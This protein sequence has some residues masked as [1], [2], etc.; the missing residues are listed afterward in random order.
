MVYGTP[1]DRRED[2]TKE[3]QTQVLG[4]TAWLSPSGQRPL[5]K[6]LADPTFPYTVSDSTMEAVHGPHSMLR[7]LPDDPRA[8]RLLVLHPPRG[9]DLE[10]PIEC[11]L[12]IE[13]LDNNPQYEA[14][15]YTCS[16]PQQ[17][18][19]VTAS[20][21]RTITQS[22]NLLTTPSAIDMILVHGR[23]FYVMTNLGFALKRLRRMEKSRVLWVDTVCISMQDLA[24][25]SAQLQHISDI[26]R[27]ARNVVAWLGEENETSERAM[28]LLTDS[29]ADTIKGIEKSL[30]E[31]DF[32]SC[33]SP[34]GAGILDELFSRPLWSRSWIIQEVVCAQQVTLHCGS[35]SID[36]D[37]MCNIANLPSYGRPHHLDGCQGLEASQLINE[38]YKRAPA[39]ALQ[40][41]RQGYLAGQRLELA[42]LLQLA[43]RHHCTAQHDKIYSILS[44]LPNSDAKSSLLKVDYNKTWEDAYSLAAEFIINKS[45]DLEILYWIDPMLKARGLPSWVPDWRHI[46]PPLLKVKLFNADAGY[47][48]ANL[49]SFSEATSTITLDR[50]VVDCITN[51]DE[52]E[53]SYSLDKGVQGLVLRINQDLIDQVPADQNKF[54]ACWR[55]ILGDH[56]VDEN[57]VPRRIR[58]SGIDPPQDRAQLEKIETRLRSQKYVHLRGQRFFYTEKG[59]VGSVASSA[60]VGDIVAILLGGKV[61][62]VLRRGQHN[63]YGRKL[64]QM[65]SPW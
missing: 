16:E 19:A 7:T 43:R 36:W 62:F 18:S 13:S 3:I 27:S 63:E 65:I 12:C 52:E 57:E 42:D 10:E 24:E 1:T 29:S 5:M 55:L 11:S 56:V 14:L 46:V 25:R 9:G 44:L 64:F 34:H 38:N 54:E 23:R 28:R 40:Q 21:P 20:R 26:F 45:Q 4:L 35:I 31:R 30:A 48:R 58:T 59:Y 53:V 39:V 60:Q 33:G 50:T 37:K 49:I 15:A 51:V 6:A 32:T 22:Q 41:L 17:K 8:L 61:P 47:S 2:A